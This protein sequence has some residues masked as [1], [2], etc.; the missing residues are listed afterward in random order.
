MT[1]AV[2]VMVASVRNFGSNNAKRRQRSVMYIPKM[3]IFAVPTQ[4]VAVLIRVNVLSSF[5]I[6]LPLLVVNSVV[7]VGN[8]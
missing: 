7:C 4:P 3:T 2:A 5:D 1:V 6:R 8:V